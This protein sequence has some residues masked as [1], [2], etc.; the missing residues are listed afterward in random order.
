[1]VSLHAGGESGGS[2]LLR[3]PV[4]GYGC[5]Q[6]YLP[7]RTMLA[8]LTGST[9]KYRRKFAALR[10]ISF[11]TLLTLTSDRYN[12]ETNVKP[13]RGVSAGLRARLC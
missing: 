12:D 3:G 4:R 13:S 7:S 6:R 10:P 9:A 11:T 1:M 8:I 5:E 2:V